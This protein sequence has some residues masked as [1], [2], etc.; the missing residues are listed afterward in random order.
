[1]SDVTELVCKKL[2][3]ISSWFTSG[4]APLLLKFIVRTEKQRHNTVIHTPFENWFH[5]IENDKQY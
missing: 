5:L 2:V 1:M 3:N 4:E